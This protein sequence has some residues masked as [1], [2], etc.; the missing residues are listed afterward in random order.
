[1]APTEG[2]SPRGR[3]AECSHHHEA[4]I[5][6]ERGMPPRLCE[7]G[8]REGRKAT[9]RQA[10]PRQADGGGGGVPA[11][12]SPAG[13][14]RPSSRVPQ[15]ISDDFE[16]RRIRSL[17]GYDMPPLLVDGVHLKP[18]ESHRRRVPMTHSLEELIEE[19][20]RRTKVIRVMGGERSELSQ[21]HAELVDTSRGW[22]GTRMPPTIWKSSTPAG[23]GCSTGGGCVE[24][25]NRS[26]PAPRLQAV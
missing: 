12:T 13:V 9:P 19:A 23:G 21:A 20:L 25:E 18:P 24:L 17:S 11:R 1:M 15:T 2:R 16:G 3:R 6:A 5:D 26:H 7:R 10:V 4:K 22:R 8:G 14:A